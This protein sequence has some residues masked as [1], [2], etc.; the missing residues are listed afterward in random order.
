MRSNIYIT[1]IN[2]R[3]AR[4]CVLQNIRRCDRPTWECCHWPSWAWRRRPGGEGRR[5]PG[6]GRGC[7]KVAVIRHVLILVVVLSPDNESC[8]RFG[9][10]RHK[11]VGAAVY[12]SIHWLV[13]RRVELFSGMGVAR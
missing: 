3:V 5:L 11:F 7:M 12:W 9:L 4:P 2:V 1:G 13:S 10:A 6:S 8:G